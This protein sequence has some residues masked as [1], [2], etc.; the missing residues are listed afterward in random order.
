MS[1]PLFHHTALQEAFA[2]LHKDLVDADGP[3]ISTM[4]NYRFAILQYDPEHEFWLRVEVQRLTTDL[5]AAGWVVFSISLQK[6]LLDRIRAQGEKSRNTS[7]PAVGR[8]ST[9]TIAV[10]RMVS[11]NNTSAC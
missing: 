3:R 2:S 4:R 1:L 8:R 7:S 11:M 6:L 10:S 5:V 9:P